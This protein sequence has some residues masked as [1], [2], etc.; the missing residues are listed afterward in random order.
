MALYVTL[1]K[2]ILLESFSIN[3]LL[4]GESV[5]LY[6]KDGILIGVAVVE[7]GTATIQSALSKGSVAIVKI[8]EKSVKIVAD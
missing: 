1:P 8:G 2:N 4:E 7:N 3:T 6:A 5:E